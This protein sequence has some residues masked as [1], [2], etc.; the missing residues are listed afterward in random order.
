M[1]QSAGW[2]VVGEAAG[3]ARVGSFTSRVGLRSETGN[4]STGIFGNLSQ[5]RLLGSVKGFPSKAAA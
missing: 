5:G 1:T 4:P 2:S 3:V